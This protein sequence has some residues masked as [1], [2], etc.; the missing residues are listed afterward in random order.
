MTYIY[1]KISS[2]DFERVEWAPSVSG[3][4]VEWLVYTG[5]CGLG[6]RQQLTVKQPLI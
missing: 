2:V 6:D 3:V 4:G 1:I 5:L